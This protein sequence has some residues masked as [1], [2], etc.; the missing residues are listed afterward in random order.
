MAAIDASIYEEL[1]IESTDGSKT[2]DVREGTVVKYYED[3][4]SPTVTVKL[5]VVNTGN[6]IDTQSIYQGLPLRGAER[7]SLKI[8]GNS[9]ENPGLDFS[10]KTNHLYVDKISNILSKSQT[11]YFVLN[12]V[13][14]E[15]ISN[16]TSRVSKKYSASSP[17][18]ASVEEI[19]KECLKT[20]KKLDI[21]QTSNTYGFIGNLRKP[22]TVVNW[23]MA[24]SVPEESK[25]GGTAGYLF[26]QTNDSYKFKSI[27]NL[28]TQEPKATYTYTEVV[29]EERDDDFIIIQY[30]TE[31]NHHILE[32]LRLGVYSSQRMFF[33]PLTFQFTSPQ[34]GAFKLE[35]YQGKSKNLGRQIELPPENPDSDRTLGDM[36]SRIITQILDVGTYEKEVS[37]KSNANPMEYQSQTLMRYNTLFTQVL[38]MTVPSNTNLN[39]GDII[40]CQFPKTSTSKEKEFDTEQSGLYMI[41][42]LCHHFDSDGSYTELVLARDTFGQYGTN[43]KK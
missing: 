23:L 26:Y 36:P 20:T 22:F 33:N 15:C 8:K 5:S 27:D 32:N 28:I 35:N 12:L 3:I 29:K 1:V 25:E 18:S 42:K 6:T 19:L 38:T 39:A 11:E 30:N 7:V 31:K 43:T 37:K 10:K 9:K 24:K 41:R 14:R 16:E 13:S 2:V 21:D 40:K 17:I 34:Q 4:F